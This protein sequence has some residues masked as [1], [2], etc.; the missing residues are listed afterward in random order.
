MKRRIEEQW[1]DFSKTLGTD[2]IAAGDV[3]LARALFFAGAMRALIA[4]NSGFNWAD[5]WP[6]CKAVMREM[7]A[8]IEADTD[9]TLARFRTPRA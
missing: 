4:L 2:A 8:E 6:A 1:Q 5:G 7:L 3:R 9:R